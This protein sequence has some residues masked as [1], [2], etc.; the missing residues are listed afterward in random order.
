M[1]AALSRAQ[2]L[3]EIVIVVD[4]SRDG[5]IE[6]L[7]ELAASEPR[8]RPLWTE[9]GGPIAALIA[10]AGAASTDV[11]VNLDDD[12]IPQPGLFSGHLGHHRD[13]PGLV[14]TGYAYM[15]P[16]PWRPGG[17]IRESFRA[18]YEA[19]CE[20]WER[21]PTKVLTELWTP[22]VSF[23]RGDL[24]R[25]A[26]DD[27]ARFGG[28]AAWYH[29]D[30]D[31]G[32]RCAALGLQGIF[33]RGLRANHEFER[34]FAGFISDARSSGHGQVLVER[35]HPELAGHAEIQPRARGPV[36][37]L[38]A[39]VQRSDRLGAAISTVLTGAV[40]LAGAL[41]SPAL[42]MR[43]AGVLKRVEQERG[44]A[45]AIRDDRS[46]RQAR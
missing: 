34:T 3:D 36:R 8:L 29:S 14:V 13:R 30:W 40:K 38:L 15:P 19:Q 44:Y 7:E 9:N 42:E 46:D 2:D 21:D 22:N 45:E 18:N 41:R 1:V 17:F 43:V 10:G 12:V 27:Q 20:R 37:A 35:L 26:A 33:D 16:E 23:R 32:L 6:L 31:L 28:G 5:S 24:L 4:G 11:V 25:V 39:L